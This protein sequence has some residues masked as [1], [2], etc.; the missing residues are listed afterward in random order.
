[1]NIEDIITPEQ[2]PSAILAQMVADLKFKNIPEEHVEYVKKD[3]L[4]E[5]ACIIAGTTG[6]SVAP[7]VEAVKEWGGTGK[8][9]ILVFGDS[10]PAPFAAFANGTIA[11]AVDMGDTHNTG[12]HICEWVI[13]ALMTGVS[14]T[15]EKK[16]G[17]EFI[18]AFV[19]GA[20]WGAREHVCIHLQFHTKE[21]PGE[22]AGSRYATGALAKFMGLRKDQI[23]AAQGMAFSAKPFSEQQKYNEGTPQVRIQHGYVCADAVKHVSLAQKGITAMKGIY[24]GESGILK[25]IKHG[26]VE[27]PDFLTQ[28]LGKRWVWREGVTM[29]PYAGCKYHHTPIYGLLSMM[30]EHNFTWQ[31]IENAHFTVS[32]GARC[33]IEP[34]EVKWNPK[35]AAEALFS[36]PYSVAYAAITG[37]CFLEAFEEEVVKEKMATPEFKELMPRL[38]FEA[39]D[40]LPTPFDNYPITVTLKDGRRFSKVESMLP[41]NV[42]NP[43]SWE[44]LEQKFWNCTR[45]SAVDLGKE[46]YQKIIDL[47]KHLD[48]L[49]DMTE[50]LEAMVP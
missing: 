39:D 9:K 29:K 49:E 36:N 2:D 45:F 48:E 43:M 12:G 17:K 46:K 42:I 31:D 10:V 33:T 25:S 14:M 15:D 27:S 4:D 23:W 16:T 47:C 7:V 26:D 41:G 1:M 28:D 20:E 32:K 38:S 24:M 50:L 21:I 44:Q 22:A 19:G 8:A 3:V 11:R 13:P 40:S 37:D 30:K 35:T 5:L 34:A 18:T 6:P